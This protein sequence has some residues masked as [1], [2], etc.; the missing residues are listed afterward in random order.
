MEMEE[1]YL[2]NG[3]QNKGILKNDNIESGGEK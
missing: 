2:F 3:G 1:Y